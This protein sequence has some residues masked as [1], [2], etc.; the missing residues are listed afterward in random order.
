MGLHVFVGFSWVRGRVR[1][2]WVR[3]LLVRVVRLSSL[4]PLPS[5]LPTS[6]FLPFPPPSLPSLLSSFTHLTSH[7]PATRTHR[8]ARMSDVEDI[9]FSQPGCK[10][11]F[12]D[13]H[14]KLGPEYREAL[15][16]WCM[17][18]KAS[19]GFLWV[20]FGEC[21]LLSWFSLLFL[22]GY[23]DEKEHSHPTIPYGALELSTS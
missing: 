20:L 6:R 14:V 10:D 8:P 12:R 9:A 21:L 3:S 7:P 2:L 11:P 16:S 17:T 15:G 4:F 19:S 5:P 23:Y 22:R 13:P 1:G 18:K